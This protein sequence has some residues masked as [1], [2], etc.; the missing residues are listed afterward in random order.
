MFFSIVMFKLII[1]KALRG[2]IK[3]LHLLQKSDKRPDGLGRYEWNSQSG[4]R[5]GILFNRLKLAPK[6]LPILAERAVTP[7][8]PR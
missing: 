8:I 7:E 2:Y 5:I 3:G 6:I 4:V 1:C